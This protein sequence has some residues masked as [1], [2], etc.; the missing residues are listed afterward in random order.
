MA[1]GSHRKKTPSEVARSRRQ[2][3]QDRSRAMVEVIVEATWKI[4][5]EEGYAAA[6]T[7]RIAER[8]GTSVGSLYQYFPNKDAIVAAVQRLHHADL[9]AVMSAAFAE[10]AGMELEPATRRLVRASL[11]AHLVDPDL[12]RT[13]SQMVPES[14][15]PETRSSLKDGIQGH[16]RDW[17]EH[18]RD[19]LTVPDLDTA[20]FVILHLVESG[21]HAAI[22][23]QDHTPEPQQVEDALTAMIVK[24]LTG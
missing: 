22:L 21:T 8:A 24:Y 15:N 3:R 23:D 9:A 17:L 16:I 4:L 19:E 13:L 5:A 1:R 20:S 7:N 18:Y 11:D 14:V 10:A 6:S 2:P 12:H